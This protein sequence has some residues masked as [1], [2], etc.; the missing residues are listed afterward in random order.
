MEKEKR[1]KQGWKKPS[2]K[3]IEKMLRSKERRKRRAISELLLQI[4]ADST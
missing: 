3:E 2:R 4:R 1:K